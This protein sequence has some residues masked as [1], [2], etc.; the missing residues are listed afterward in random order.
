MQKRTALLL[1]PLALALV[2]CGGN[3]PYANQAGQNPVVRWNQTMLQAIRNT[4]LGPPMTARAIGVVYTSMYDAWAAYDQR[5][6]GVHWPSDIRRPFGEQS[7]S[8]KAKAVAFAAHRTLSNLYPSQQALFDAELVAQGFDPADSSTNLAQP[9]GVGNLCAQAVTSFRQS[10][11]SNQ[12]NNYADT[13]GYV[14]VNTVDTVT[15]P[16][17]WQPLRFSNGATPGFV[18]PHFGTVKPFGMV[19]GSQF[20]PGAVFA[21][22]GTQAYR[23]QAQQIIDT[24]ANLTDREKVIAEYWANGPSSELP[25]G[26]WCIFAQEVS[27]RDNHSLDDDVKMF[28]ALGN[29]LMDAG[30]AAWDAKR[31]YDNSRPITCVRVLNAGKQVKLWNGSM[32]DGAQWVPYQ[33]GAFITPPF[34]EFVSGHSTF[35]AAGAEILKR[36]T[37]NDR[38]GSSATIA[39]RSLVVDVNA[40]SDPVT[41]SWGT[42]TEAAEEAGESRILGGIHFQPANLEGQALGRKVANVVWNKAQDYINGTIAP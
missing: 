23:D 19:T 41:L 34:A 20:R 8:N 31:A 2:S 17:R 9:A 42:F 28:F 18:G 30:I 4:R 36:F 27:Q 39:P 3:T 35:S 21:K 25:P 12:L 16:D 13:S 10:D 32:V 33:P 40:P 11:N 24:A 14:P 7:E 37:G 5:A 29:A 26:H 22:F 38:F 1:L 15:D 6:V